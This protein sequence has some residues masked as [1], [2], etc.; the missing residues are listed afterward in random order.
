MTVSP[1]IILSPTTLQVATVGNEYSQQLTASGGSG[2]R[3]PLR[4][5]C[6]PS[7]PIADHNG[8]TQ[9]DAETAIGSPFIVAVTVT[10]G[11]GSTGKPDLRSDSQARVDHWVDRL[12]ARSSYYGRGSHSH[13]HLLG[14]LRW[15]GQHDRDGRLLRWENLLGD[16][17]AVRHG[18]PQEMSP[19]R[20]ACRRR[21][22]SVGDH[23]ITAVY[24]GDS[25]YSAATVESPVS[26]EVVAA[27]TSIALTASITAQRTILTAT[28]VRTSPGNPPV[29]GCVFFYDGT[30]FSGPAR[31][32]RGRDPERRVVGPRTHARSAPFFSG[33]G[34]FSASESSLDVSTHGPR[35]TSVLR[36]GFHWQPTYLLINFNGRLDPT[37]A[38][39]PSNYQSSGPAATGSRSSWPST[40][41]RLI[42]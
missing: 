17:T 16:R 18:R 15:F 2:R 32:E 12:L 27:V 25:R 13:R 29:V 30:R 40:T 22:L 33:G 31:V 11:D 7:R 36:Y 8:P 28:F 41:R 9:R 26:V 24:S 3:L 20:P 4:G 14:D 19:G 37:S 6:T 1:A 21:P 34:T 23:I 10:D 5:E 38:Q 42:P 39:N 35:V